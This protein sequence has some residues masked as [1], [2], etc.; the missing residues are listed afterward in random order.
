MKYVIGTLMLLFAFTPKLEAGEI[1]IKHLK[2]GADSK[3]YGTQDSSIQHLRIEFHVTAD[4]EAEFKAIMSSINTLMANEEGFI[5]AK[6]FHHKD[7]DLRFTLIEKWVSYEAHRRHYK[8]INTN[9]EWAHLLRMLE[10][11]PRLVYMTEVK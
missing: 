2:V 7:N 3:P 11:E 5:S 8:K 9:G 1:N 4:A 6:A 10:R